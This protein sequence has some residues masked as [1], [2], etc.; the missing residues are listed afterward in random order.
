M[1]R[2]WSQ[3]K[4]TCYS[5]YCLNWWVTAAQRISSLVLISCVRSEA[6]SQTALVIILMVCNLLLQFQVCVSFSLSWPYVAA[7]QLTEGV[8]FSIGF[9]GLLATV[10]RSL[11]LQRSSLGLS[12]SMLLL[13]P[14]SFWSSS[15]LSTVWCILFCQ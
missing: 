14:C 15:L 6:I 7:P 12:W 3:S 11:V 9:T 10:R 13:G 4:P 2:A 1:D 5:W 8:P